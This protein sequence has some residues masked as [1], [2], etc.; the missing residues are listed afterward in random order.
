M[1]AR[2]CTRSFNASS[3]ALPARPV[4][5]LSEVS[6]VEVHGERLGQGRSLRDVQ[7][8]DDAAWS[9][10]VAPARSTHRGVTQGRQQARE[11]ALPRLGQ[12][13]VVEPGKQHDIGVQQTIQAASSAGPGPMTSHSSP[14][15]SQHPRSTGLAWP[16]R[17]RPSSA[18]ATDPYIWVVRC[19]APP[20][21]GSLTHVSFFV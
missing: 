13:L 11:L 8:I 20:T 4:P 15:D 12:D 2:R 19:T 10:L 17:T 6:Q 7:G 16:N 18:A 14:P 3:A 21:L 5:F 9:I 1:S